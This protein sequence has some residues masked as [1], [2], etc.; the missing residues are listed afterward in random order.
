M[1]AWHLVT[2]LPDDDMAMVLAVTADER[3]MVWRVGILRSAMDQSRTP[4]HLQFPATHFVPIQDLL[5]LLRL[6]GIEKMNPYLLRDL[7]PRE[8]EA[9]TVGHAFTLVSLI[10]LRYRDNRDTTA[11]GRQAAQ[12]IADAIAAIAKA[13]G[14]PL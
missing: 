3:V 7:H 12:D 5:A 14:V 10:A 6:G 9:L 13:W 4:G 1:I 11:E 2:D 8:G